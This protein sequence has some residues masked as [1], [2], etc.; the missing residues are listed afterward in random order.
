MIYGKPGSGKSTLALQYAGHLAEV[1]NQRILYVAAEEGLSYTMK[2]KLAR[3]GIKSRNL[4]IVDSLPSNK[5]LH[6]YDTI[7]IDS[8][9]NA[10]LMPEDLRRLPKDKS[11]V[12]VMQT[13]KTGLFRGSQE[14]LHD[15]DTSIKVDSMQAYTEK[16]RFGA[17]GG[18]S[19]L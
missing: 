11:Y 14:F 6:K 2:E 17:M 7:F 3:L 1:H 15:V 10:G 19:V 5:E 13:T 16:N 8:V 18:C 4:T 9:N 12:Y